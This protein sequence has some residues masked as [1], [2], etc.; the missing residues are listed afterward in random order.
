MHIS[1]CFFVV[2]L[3]LLAA[4]FLL[5]LLVGGGLGATPRK[6]GARYLPMFVGGIPVLSP[7]VGFGG[8]SQFSL[9][10]AGVPCLES[11]CTS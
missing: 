10:K 7:E 3:L 8:V 9:V 6:V 11:C 4:V 1:V 5:L 2:F